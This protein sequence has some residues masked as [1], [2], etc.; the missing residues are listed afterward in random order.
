MIK[1]NGK[2]I[3]INKVNNITVENNVV[4]VNGKRINVKEYSDDYIIN[5]EVGGDVHG[6][7]HINGNIN[8]YGDINGDI[9]TNGNVSL[10]R[11]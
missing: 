4:I 8:C 6:D 3:G 9:D 1:I 2:S 11:K 7:I 10:R 5:I